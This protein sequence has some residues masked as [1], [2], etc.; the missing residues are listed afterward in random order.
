MYRIAKNFT[1]H[2]LLTLVISF[3]GEEYQGTKMATVS[4]NENWIALC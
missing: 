2:S 1:H 3:S 4:F